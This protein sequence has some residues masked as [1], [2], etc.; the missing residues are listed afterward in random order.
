MNRAARIAVA[1]LI[2]IAIA[3]PA[4]ILLFLVGSFLLWWWL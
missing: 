2:G 1:A 4:I 3:I